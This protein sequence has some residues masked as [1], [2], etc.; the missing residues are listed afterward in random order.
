MDMG[1]NG[2][3]VV[4]TGG[5]S[6][7]GKSFIPAFQAEGCHVAVCGRNA[8]VN[9]E[10]AAEYPDILAVQADVTR[11]EDMRRLAEEAERRFGGIDIWINNAG[12]TGSAPLM[13]MPLEDWDRMMNINLRAVLLCTRVA[14]PYL[15][16]RGGGVI[17]NA[18]SFASII[19]SAFAG[20]YSVSKIGVNTLTAVFAAELAPKNIRVAAYA[21]GMFNTPMNTTAIAANAEKLR[22]PVALRRFGEVEEIAPAVVFLASQH[23]SFITGTILTVSGGKLCVQNP[24]AV[25]E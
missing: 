20:A 17:L 16:R 6:G 15:E 11:E 1:L 8:K 25:W 10:I 4:I 23:A 14:A 21:P 9:A 3:V 12:I 13:D 19:P 2:K 24:Q 22:A 18:S 5:T 7:F